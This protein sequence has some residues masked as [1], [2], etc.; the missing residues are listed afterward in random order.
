MVRDVEWNGP[1][2][3]PCR[4]ALSQGG[5]NTG[6]GLGVTTVSGEVAGETRQVA[7]RCLG[8]PGGIAEVAL[9]I[10]KQASERPDVL[11]VVPDDSEESGR[12]TVTQELEIP[13]RYLRAG[14]VAMAPQAEQRG[15]HGLQPSIRHSVAKEAAHHRQQVQVAG[16]HGWAI[17]PHAIA[18]HDQR[19]VEASAVVRDQP[20]RRRDVPPELRQQRRLVRLVGQEELGLAEHG[21]FPPPEPDQERQCPGRRGEP[22]RL[23]IETDQ[24]YSGRRLTGQ[25]GEPVALNRDHHGALFDSDVGAGR[26]PDQLTIQLSCESLGAGSH[27]PRAITFI[28]PPGRALQGPEVG[29]ASLECRGHPG[30]TPRTGRASAQVHRGP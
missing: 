25:R 26:G 7:W 19:P 17:L 12:L 22:C 8:S 6:Q 2:A 16:V 29:E 20:G 9:D 18:G 13:S 10:G 27:L 15:L 1:L 24:G 14:H 11:V 4:G 23:G 30:V 3:G 28:E 21:P 5:F